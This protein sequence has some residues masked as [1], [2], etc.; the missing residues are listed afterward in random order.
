MERTA[1]T[2]AWI[3]FWSLAVMEF[4]I[5]KGEPWSAVA[6]AIRVSENFLP[7]P[8]LFRL[9]PF[10]LKQVQ[11]R[12]RFAISQKMN[13]SEGVRKYLKERNVPP[14]GMVEG[15]FRS[16]RAK[17]DTITEAQQNTLDQV[18]AEGFKCSLKTVQRRT[19]SGI[20]GRRPMAK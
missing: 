4:H 20:K 17:G 16:Y 12:A 15:V 14:A 11:P 6:H 8:E 13:G 7:G 19:S 18:I 9:N 2:I 3:A 10:G 5:K 1:R